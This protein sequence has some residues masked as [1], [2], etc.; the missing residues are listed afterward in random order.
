MEA[1][2]MELRTSWGTKDT[3]EF[4]GKGN[5]VK[6]YEKTSKKREHERQTEKKIHG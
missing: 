2:V 4:K 6:I 3:N 1:Q 5:G